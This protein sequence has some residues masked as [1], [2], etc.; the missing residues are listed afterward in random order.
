MKKVLYSDIEMIHETI[1]E[2]Q[3]DMEYINDVL[4][5]YCDSM[6]QQEKK[7]G[8]QIKKA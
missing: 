8:A 3:G 1:Q 2:N 6:V 5:T 7:F 4:E